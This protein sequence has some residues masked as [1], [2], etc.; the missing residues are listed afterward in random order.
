MNEL[1]TGSGCAAAA[2]L[3]WKKKQKTQTLAKLKK[4][5]ISRVKLFK[6]L[7]MKNIFKKASVQLLLLSLLMTIAQ[8]TLGY[9]VQTVPE[10]DKTILLRFNARH[11]VAYAFM[12]LAYKKQKKKKKIKE[13]VYK[14][15]K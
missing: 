10:V 4:E 12:T 6:T 15:T 7:K 3:S 1:F 8:N 2:S 13:M 14:K 9:D 11:I 5:R